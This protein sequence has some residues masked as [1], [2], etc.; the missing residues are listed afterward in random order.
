MYPNVLGFCLRSIMQ[1]LFSTLDNVVRHQRVVHVPK[2][3]GS[4]DKKQSSLQNSA[5]T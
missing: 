5:M 1:V 2:S 4:V 3:Q